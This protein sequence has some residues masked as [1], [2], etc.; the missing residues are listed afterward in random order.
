MMRDGAASAALK[1]AENR[2]LA[3]AR[4]IHMAA[5]TSGSSAHSPFTSR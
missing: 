4:R 5:E 3:R 2:A 1:D